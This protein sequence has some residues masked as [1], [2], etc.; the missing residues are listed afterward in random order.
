MLGAA[1]GVHFQ[2]LSPQ[3]SY[4]MVSFLFPSF[5]SDCISK[6]SSAPPPRPVPLPPGQG[7]VGDPWEPG[8]E[9]VGWTQRRLTFPSIFF[10]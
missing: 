6:W 8:T 10:L 2:S 5:L 9:W 7:M 3:L 1:A 4:L